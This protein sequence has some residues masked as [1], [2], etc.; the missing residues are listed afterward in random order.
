MYSA[1]NNRPLINKTG[2]SVR[3]GLYTSVLTSD[4]RSIFKHVTCGLMVSLHRQ[5]SERTLNI[6][7]QMDRDIYR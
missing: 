5:A 4:A 7:L 1:I 2:I 6:M 3:M